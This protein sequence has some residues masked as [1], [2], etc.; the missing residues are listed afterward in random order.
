MIITTE[1]F[2]CPKCGRMPWSTA[3]LEIPP[4]WAGGWKSITCRRCGDTKGDM[5]CRGETA[6]CQVDAEW[7]QFHGNYIGENPHPHGRT[8]SYWRQRHTV[9]STVRA[10]RDINGIWEDD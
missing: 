9:E 7:C 5:V 6:A 8:A 4:G 3:R 10:K 2:W 1:Q